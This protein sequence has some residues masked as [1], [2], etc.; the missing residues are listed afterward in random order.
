[1][2]G[3]KFL[4]S[5]DNSPAIK[6]LADVAVNL[7]KINSAFRTAGKT[8]G[9]GSGGA[10]DPNELKNVG[11]Q[12]K[13]VN[14]IIKSMGVSQNQWQRDAGFKGL[15]Q[16]FEDVTG[17]A[18]GLFSVVTSLLTPI[19]ALTGAG[20]I[21][22]LARAA[23][24]FNLDAVKTKTATYET[25]MSG[26]T[27]QKWVNR[28]KVFNIDPDVMRSGWTDMSQRIRAIALGKDAPA[29]STAQTILGIKDI[30]GRKN[31]PGGMEDLTNEF[32]YKINKV[33]SEQ[34]DMRQT[35]I[36][37]FG[38]GYMKPMMVADP[39]T[40]KDQFAWADKNLPV[41]NEARVEKGYQ[42]QFSVN[43]LFA[44]MGG[45]FSRAGNRGSG[46]LSSVSEGMANL[47][48]G[49]PLRGDQQKNKY[50]PFSDLVPNYYRN[51]RDWSRIKNDEGSSR[52]SSSD[53]GSMLLPDNAPSGIAIN[54]PAPPQK[55]DMTLTINGVPPGSK[56]TTTSNPNVR[57][58]PTINYSTVGQ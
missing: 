52:Q 9:K 18:K 43:R 39:K 51:F 16:G 17:S 53:D 14:D 38:V 46:V 34:P 54:A 27:I 41:F 2:A 36:D 3:Y 22:G 11:A 24:S 19:E 35:M 25:G 31:K 33:G 57:V 21:T 12:L 5:A 6:A 40:L 15:R 20:V 10:F 47:I 37:T 23:N 26:K 30:I 8:A 32:M 29:L 45:F 48:N 50:T 44:S 55:V 28:G 49:Q 1:M 42:A 13:T 7:K 4:I 56:L 58:R